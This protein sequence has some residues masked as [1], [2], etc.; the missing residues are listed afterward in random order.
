[1]SV[2]LMCAILFETGGTNESIGIVG[3]E[4]QATQ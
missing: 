1:M 4:S 2:L 3:V